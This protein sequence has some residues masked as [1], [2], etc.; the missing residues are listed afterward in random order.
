MNKPPALSPMLAA[1][2]SGLNT[3]YEITTFAYTR[4]SASASASEQRAWENLPRVVLM[5]RQLNPIAYTTLN[6]LVL[7]QSDRDVNVEYIYNNRV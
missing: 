6:M 3:S 1:T 4:A 5:L 7:P 2:F